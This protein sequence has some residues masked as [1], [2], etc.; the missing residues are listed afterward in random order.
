MAD[1]MEPGFQPDP[2]AAL[3]A[4]IAREKEKMD[5]L[6][7]T[8]AMMP[9]IWDTEEEV[10]AER[11][12]HWVDINIGAARAVPG[13]AEESFELLSELDEKMMSVVTA[14]GV[15][16][17]RFGYDPRVETISLAVNGTYR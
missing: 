11:R 15:P 3:E 2:L 17:F 7:T 10:S 14:W 8:T 4:R 9:E 1:E 6:D 12:G 13:W 5:T 16:D